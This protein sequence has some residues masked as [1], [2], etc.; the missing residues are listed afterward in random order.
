[1]PADWAATWFGVHPIARARASETAPVNTADGRRFDVV[2]VILALPN[3]V[4][5][6]ENIIDA[7]EVIFLLNL[8]T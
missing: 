5:T 4:W 8:A 2:N 3:G 1:V 6:L 7:R